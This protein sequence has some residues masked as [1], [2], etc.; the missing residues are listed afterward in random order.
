MSFSVEATLAEV[1]DEILRLQKIEQSLLEAAGS[2]SQ[3]TA[4]KGAAPK[5]RLSQG[6]SLVIAL[7]AKLRH[8]RSKGDK[9]VVRQL[10]KQL[11]AAKAAKAKA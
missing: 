8:A 4:S 11:K 10:E 5:R 2:A 3:P 6:G 1:R 9:G 7:A